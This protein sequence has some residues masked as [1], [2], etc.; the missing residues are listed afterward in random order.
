MRGNW[1]RHT[2]TAFRLVKRCIYASRVVL[3]SCSSYSQLM[4]V[5]CRTFLAFPTAICV[6]LTLFIVL[7]L[8]SRRS[9]PRWVESGSPFHELPRPR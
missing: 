1:N 9:V 8:E 5:L 7:V 3:F 2:V 4:R 6:L